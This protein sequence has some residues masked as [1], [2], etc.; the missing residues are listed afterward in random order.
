MKPGASGRKA[1][2]SAVWQKGIVFVVA[3]AFVVFAIVLIHR[4][5]DLQ[6]NQYEEMSRQA[7]DL[8]WQAVPQSPERGNIYDANGNLLAGTTYT[9][10]VG[11]TPAA[12]R[13]LASEKELREDVP[14][15]NGQLI[16]ILG[17]EPQVVLEAMAQENATYVVLAKNV[18]SKTA[19]RLEAY[20]AKHAVG[21]IR[22]DP[23]PKR[24]Y[25]NGSLASHVLG[26]ARAENDTLV[27]QQG[28]ELWYNR[29]LT[30]VDGKTY[31]EMARGKGAL[32][33]QE[34]L[35][36][37]A[38]DGYNL[39]L[40]IDK[41][42]QEFAERECRNV[43]ETY[44]TGGS[45]TAIVMNVHT[46]AVLANANY[47]DYDSNT[48]YAKPDFMDEAD[49]A[50][51]SDEEQTEIFL[52][53]VWKNHAISGAV[54]PGSTMK[55]LTT[56]MA[57]EEDLVYESQMFK[58]TPIETADAAFMFRCSRE[59][60]Y[61]ENHGEETFHRAF[62]NSCNP[63]FVQLA[64][65][66]GLKRFYTYMEEFGFLS[67]TGIDLPGEAQGYVVPNKIDFP[68][69]PGE[70][71]MWSLSI[72]ESASVTPMQLITAYAAL[73]NGGKLMV[74]QIAKALVDQDGNVVK[75]F[76][77]QVQ[78]TIFSE[79]TAARIRSLMEEVVTDGT[80]SIAAIPGYSIAGKTGTSTIEFGVD[81]GLHVLSFGAYA[82]SNDPE[83]V[84]LVIVDRPA[85]K[86]V[87]SSC[88]SISASR[89]IENTL[90]Y[91]G[92]QRRY[93][94]D[95]DRNLMTEK[96]VVPNVVGMTYKEAKKVLFQ[97]KAPLLVL[98][99]EEIADENQIVTSMYPVAQTMLYRGGKVTLF[100]SENPEVAVD[101]VV[102]DF[103]GKTLAEIFYEA[104]KSRINIQITGDSKGKAV[105][106][107]IVEDSSSAGTGDSQED[108]DA[109]LRQSTRRVRSGTI[110]R[111]EMKV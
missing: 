23:V 43:Y 6:L 103:T 87:G 95:A 60:T 109:E 42:I 108:G 80:A 20:M 32:S 35:T 106:Q 39:T 83:I 105:S 102:P 63:V 79:K 68:G 18:D 46:G 51:L 33:F 14:H 62:A 76:E 77:P 81:K 73:A 55:A 49:W 59:T 57:F 2:S 29:E 25:V 45:V 3:A 47:P 22:L 19:E 12:V 94:S 37:E 38:E 27:G 75:E 5:Y 1:S 56:V 100:V 16:T 30:G 34:P 110:I 101:T 41:V 69:G 70:V 58:D 53:T 26:Y 54:E 78:R 4:L 67:T 17:L 93:K 11:I 85:D 89:I 48:P 72:G 21:G 64:Q 98:D 61:G 111:I 7:S 9:Y 88:A 86:E 104:S 82:P 66:I 52:G 13:S 90:S 31:A 92:V 97:G 74:P 91:L 96:V 15:I 107:E 40:N 28:V 8:H 10:T 50:A 36:A 99:G 84:V 71:D 44:E 65:K 24:Y